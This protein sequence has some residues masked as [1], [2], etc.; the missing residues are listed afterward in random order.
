MSPDGFFAHNKAEYVVL[1]AFPLQHCVR[2]LPSVLR[3]MY[4]GCPVGIVFCIYGLH[5]MVLLKFNKESKFYDSRDFTGIF[6]SQFYLI[7]Y[8]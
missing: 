1:S 2:D 5:L 8:S 7:Q 4:I 6:E 3:Y